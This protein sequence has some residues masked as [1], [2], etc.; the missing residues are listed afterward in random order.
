MRKY[1]QAKLNL[2]K[3]LEKRNEKRA[4][5]GGIKEEEFHELFQNYTTT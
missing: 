1:L 4:L 2:W 5:V 3:K